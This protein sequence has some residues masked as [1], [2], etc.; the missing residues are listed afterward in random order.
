VKSVTRLLPAAVLFCGLV[1]P[2]RADNGTSVTSGALM[3]A[4]HVGVID[5]AGQH[6]FQM[7]SNVDDVGGIFVP[8]NQCG[9]LDCSPGT[10]VNL[11]AKWSGNDLSGTLAFKGKSY[12]LGKEGPSGA[13]GIVDFEGSLVLPPFNDS[14]TVDVSAPFTFS[15]QLEFEDTL[16]REPLSGAGIA[17]L[18]FKRSADGSAWQFS[19]AT[20][21]LQKQP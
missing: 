15:G 20:Y 16:A 3:F 8:Q 12:P 14:G 1:L 17:T 2:L 10:T 13:L 7:R 19:N 6:N 11:E 18:Q 5:I 9:D 4:S 21:A